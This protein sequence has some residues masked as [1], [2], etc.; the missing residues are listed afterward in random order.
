MAKQLPHVLEMSRAESTTKKYRSA[1]N[2]WQEWARRQSVPAAPADPLHVSLYL[3]KL[4]NSAKSPSPISSAVHGISWYH[5]INGHEDPCQNEIVR[6]VHQ[7]A[8]R[9]LS[10]PRQRKQPLSRRVL[11]KLGSKL[12][13][14]KLVNLQTLTLVTLGYAGFLRWDDLAHVYAD[15]I[16]I[17]KEYMV[18][19]LEKRKNDQFREGSW[20]FVSRWAGSLCPVDLVEQLLL[21]GKHQGHVPLFGRVR[22]RKGGQVIRDAMS[23]SRAR[24]LVQE[25]LLEVGEEADKYSLHSLRSGGV[26]VAAAAGVPD[27]L[28]QRHGGWKSESG[29]KCYFSECL[30]KLLEVSRA[31]AV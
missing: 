12:D 2:R 11:K 19:F 7:A 4:L 1:F 30:P 14:S 21:R 15:E 17:K 22:S 23:Y 18:I 13:R 5:C 31:I 24:E 27:R 26:S 16:Y 25:A 10:K 9:H 29:M 8:R 20:I 6:R 3:I 28:I